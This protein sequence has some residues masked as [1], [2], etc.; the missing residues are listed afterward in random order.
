MIV[1]NNGAVALI[2]LVGAASPG[3]AP[4]QDYPS[5]LI[6]LVTAE[7]GGPSDVVARLIAQSIAEPLGQTVIVDNRAGVIAVETVVKAAPDGYTLLFYG[8]SAY[9]MPLL[10]ASSW[11][12]VRDLAPI[13]LATRAPNLVVV[14]PALPV[15]SVK[16]LIALAKARPGQIN[17]ASGTIGSSNHLAAEL[18]KSMAHVNIVRV[19]YKGTSPAINAVIG[20]ELQLMFPDLGVA[21]GHV[22]SGRLRALA[23]TSAQPSPLA[24]GVPTLAASGVPG[25]SSEILLGMFAPAGTPMPVI[26]RLQQEIARV[27]NSGQVKEKLYSVGVEPVGSSPQQ[28]GATVRAEVAKW[29]KVVKEA[30]IREQ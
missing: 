18:F 22:K 16:E 29:S 17:Y 15:K 6:R 12:A 26:E 14:H 2:W 3:V 8:P 21:S 1:A 30:N 7:P 23:I 9:M 11:D 4:A 24:P 5:K 10:R 19:G 27:L 20:G 28:F 13:T 25:Y